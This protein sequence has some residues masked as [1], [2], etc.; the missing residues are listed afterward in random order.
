M[1]L[2]GELL[3]LLFLMS[4]ANPVKKSKTFLRL[5]T[6][7][8]ENCLTISPDLEHIYKSL[9]YRIRFLFQITPNFFCVLHLYDDG[10]TW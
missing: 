1:I 8:S 9:F 10:I 3:G 7:F 6:N 4:I 5:L 2:K